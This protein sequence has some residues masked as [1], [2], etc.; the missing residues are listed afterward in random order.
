M[1]A[2]NW[3]PKLISAFRSDFWLLPQTVLLPVAILA[4]IRLG[5][6]ARTQKWLRSWSAAPNV[7]TPVAGDTRRIISEALRAQRV[8]RRWSGVGGSCLVRSFTL[9]ALLRKR[10]LETQIRIGM[11]KRKNA[12]EGHA[13][14]EYEGKPINETGAEV[15]TYSVYHESI[16]FD[17]WRGKKAATLP[18]VPNRNTAER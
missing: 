14:V 7:L 5:G 18:D 6:V 3:L 10:G 15:A 11:R 1:P 2:S 16:A 4:G 8:V 9:W 12:T 17:A 13:W